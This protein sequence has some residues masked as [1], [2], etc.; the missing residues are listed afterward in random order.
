LINNTNY[1]PLAPH[2][3]YLATFFQLNSEMLS[4][5]ARIDQRHNWESL[6]WEWPL[7]AS[8]QNSNCCKCILL[9]LFPPLSSS[10]QLRGI[11]YYSHTEDSGPSAGSTQTIYLLGNPAAIWIVAIFLVVAFLFSFI[12]LRY[13]EHRDMQLRRDFG[14]VFTAVGYC[15]WAYV[16]NLLPYILVNRSAFI[17]HY[18]PALMYGEVV[19]ALMVEQLAGPRL[20][21][22]AVKV[23]TL[24][25]LAGFVFWAPWVYCFPLTA[26]GHARRRIL[27]RWD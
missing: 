5:N 23:L 7:N 13:R 16:L 17:Y 6:W 19:A 25:V 10:P 14:G 2:P 20:T 22:A 27:K 24:V 9:T 15:L 8:T 11:L 1:D 12:F 3:G 21:P 26:E 18:M 4:A